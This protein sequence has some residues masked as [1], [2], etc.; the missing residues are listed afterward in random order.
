MTSLSSESFKRSLER[1]ERGLSADQKKYCK[2]SNLGQIEAEINAEVKKIQDKYGPQKKLRNLARLNGFFEGMKQIEE[3]VKIFLNVHEV[4]AFVWVRGL[5]C[6]VVSNHAKTLEILIDAYDDIGRFLKGIR[7]YDRLFR[8][9]SCAREVLEDCF[10]DVLRFHQAAL[11]ELARPRWK[12]MAD[13]LWP[14][15]KTRFGPILKSLESRT[16][17]LSDSKVSAAIEEIQTTRDAT[18]EKLQSLEDILEKFLKTQSDD[19]KQTE[20]RRAL[21]AADRQRTD[22]ESMFMKLAPSD[23]EGDHLT[24]SAQR[25][26]VA[27]G[28]WVLQDLRFKEWM[29]GTTSDQ[30]VLYLNG[31]P[32]SGKTTLVS[33]IIDHIKSEKVSLGG[34]L[35]YFYFK[36]NRAGGTSGTAI[37]RMLRALL[38]QFLEQDDGLLG[39]IQEKCGSLHKPTDLQESILKSLGKDC[40]ALQHRCWIVVDGLDECNDEHQADKLESLEVMRWFMGEVLPTDDNGRFPIRLLFSGQRDGYIDRQLSNCAMINLDTTESHVRDVEHYVNHMAMKIKSRFHITQSRATEIAQKVSITA[41]GMFLYAKVVLANLFDQESVADLN[42]ELSQEKFPKELDA[43]YGRVVA[44]ILDRPRPQ[45]SKTAATILGWLVCSP[46]ALRWREIQSRFCINAE[47]QTCDF[48]RRRLDGCKVLCG[49]LV[50]LDPCEYQ[51]DSE[52][53]DMISLVHNTARSYLLQSGR[54]SLSMEHAKLALFCTQYLASAPF[55]IQDQKTDD[56]LASALTGYYGLLDYA[57]AYWKEHV[58]QA[59]LSENDVDDDTKQRLVCFSKCLLASQAGHSRTDETDSV[60]LEVIMDSPQHDEPCQPNN[61]IPQDPVA[62]VRQ[63]IE[64]IDHTTLTDRARQALLELNGIGRFKCTVVACSKFAEGF[65]KREDRDR[66]TSNHEKPFKCSVSGCHAQRVGYGSQKGLDAHNKRLHPAPSDGE[67]LFATSLPIKEDTIHSAASRGDLESVKFFLKSGSP[68]DKPTK[69][70]GGMTPLFLATRF[71]HANAC[72]YLIQQGAN[73]FEERIAVSPFMEAVSRGDTEMVHLFLNAQDNPSPTLGQLHVL[74]KAVATLIIAGDTTNFKVLLEHLSLYFDLA[75]ALTEI[76]GRL[77]WDKSSWNT[78]AVKNAKLIDKQVSL[79]H[80]IVRMA[81]PQL[82]KLGS[83]LP[84]LRIDLT[85][86]DLSCLEALRGIFMKPWFIHGDPPL[87]GACATK[88]Y[89]VAEFVL[90][91][92]QKEDI[93]FAASPGRAAL[94]RLRFSV[95]E[96]DRLLPGRLYSLV[97]RI[98]EATDGAAANVKDENGEFPIHHAMR[99]YVPAEVIKVLMQYTTCLD[100]LTNYGDTPLVLAVDYNYSTAVS[101]L[102]ESG[103]VS[104]TR[105]RDHQTLS[106]DVEES[107]QEYA[108]RL[109]RKAGE[110]ERSEEWLQHRQDI[111]DILRRAIAEKEAKTSSGSGN[112]P[113]PQAPTE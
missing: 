59:T 48:D 44:R 9:Y 90:E 41:N 58:Q 109:K 38:T 15:I 18:S 73:P 64:V 95:E 67:V 91:F 27:S 29:N 8:N 100:V 19:M 107:M 42:D 21:E 16:K 72:S 83:S 40:I 25:Y 60:D 47:K 77:V 76:L 113:S 81:F 102:V 28:D 6:I 78:F 51:K 79:L 12:K 43:A 37:S 69:E 31:M 10:D 92:L 45:R 26:D 22:K 106:G 39:R 57:A 66:H 33:R 34:S 17:I 70:R 86:S 87:N 13:S 68:I 11:E 97:R 46:R 36:H 5:I 62:V 84:Q 80:A 50:E 71:G 55:N 105:K 4:V 2:S 52:S 61:E 63:V 82:Y 98:L 56:I 75:S 54:I 30:S 35:A 108:Q 103:R 93:L 49:S 65:S 89:F 53:E 20:E 74:G 1:F 24:A 94:S 110:W 96:I 104:L 23:Y 32:G 99:R 3:L 88:R 111:V 101:L 7:Q 112:L 85:P 14:H